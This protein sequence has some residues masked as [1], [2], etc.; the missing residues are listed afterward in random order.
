M[1][2]LAALMSADEENPTDPDTMQALATAGIA[3]G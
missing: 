1:E 2:A 3:C